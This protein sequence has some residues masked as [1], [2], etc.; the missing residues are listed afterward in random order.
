MSSLFS[1]VKEPPK[2]FTT[3]ADIE[4]WRLNVPIGSNPFETH[5]I[6][7]LTIDCDEAMKKKMENVVKILSQL[8]S[9]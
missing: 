8:S 2:R 7:P 9:K 5:V 6:E 3:K 1:D 4:E